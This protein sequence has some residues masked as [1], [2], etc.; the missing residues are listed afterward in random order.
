MELDPIYP[1]K[2]KDMYDASCVVVAVYFDEEE[3]KGFGVSEDSL[4]V[5]EPF[6]DYNEYEKPF[7]L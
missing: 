6:W 2:W 7:A 5:Q 1:D 3:L 4:E